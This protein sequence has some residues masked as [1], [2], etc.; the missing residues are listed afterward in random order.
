MSNRT[1]RRIRSGLSSEVAARYGWDQKPDVSERLKGASASASK[2][3]SS[4]G[5][6]W[7]IQIEGFFVNPLLEL[8]RGTSSGYG[9][10]AG[11]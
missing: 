5:K 4:T 9:Q 8:D 11:N 3:A 6:V 7:F 10:N 1:F 2:G